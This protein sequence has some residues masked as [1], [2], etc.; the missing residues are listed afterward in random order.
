[1]TVTD[2]QFPLGY[3]Y[4]ISKMNEL[5]IDLR[6]PETATVSYLLFLFSY[7]CTDKLNRFLPRLLCL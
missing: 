5:V 7:F 1:M 2:S 4:I 3:F 6:G